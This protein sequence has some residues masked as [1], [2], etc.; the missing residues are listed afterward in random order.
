VSSQPSINTA[1][2]IKS[3]YLPQQSLNKKP[4]VLAQPLL[5]KREVTPSKNDAIEKKALDK[6]APEN[7]NEN[8]EN[9][10]NN[11]E[12]SDNASRTS[13]STP[14]MTASTSSRIDAE[15][16]QMDKSDSTNDTK[17]TKLPVI[18][19]YKREYSYPVE[20][21]TDEENMW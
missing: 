20:G 4:P 14:L 15:S 19:E 11:E 10:K 3:V 12:I 13:E 17:E 1:Q 6:P 7:N 8:K 16:I 9:L 21:Y 5:K 2:T 18:P